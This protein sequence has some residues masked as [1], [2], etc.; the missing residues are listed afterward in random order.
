TSLVRV[1][2]LGAVG[3]PGF[4][5]LPSDLLV[6]DAIM[7]AGGP[8]KNADLSR[9]EVRRG[10]RVTWPKNRFRTAVDRGLTLDQMDIRPGDAIMVAQK[11]SHN[12]LTTVQTVGIAVGIVG[13][14][15]A[16]RHR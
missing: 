11:P 5:S 4:Y 3:K 13:T 9:T 10:N 7:A 15:I 16:I 2:V 1:D 6:S 8:D 12:W 14:I